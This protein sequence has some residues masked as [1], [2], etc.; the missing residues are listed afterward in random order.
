MKKI[1]K[2]MLT[3]F[4]VAFAFVFAACG[5]NVSRFEG[6]L[7][8]RR[9]NVFVGEI[10]GV[11]VQA[12]TGQREEPFIL[13]GKA[14]GMQ[15]FTLI[16]I[17][18]DEFMGTVE[19]SYRVVIGENEFR[20]E[21]VPHPFGRTYSTNI[22]HLSEVEDMTLYL[23]RGDGEEKQIILKSVLTEDM[24]DYYKALSIAA[25]RLEKQIDNMTQNGVLYAEIFVRLM[26]NPVDNT[27]GFYWYV[28]FL[29]PEGNMYAA[30]IHPVSMEIVAV[31]D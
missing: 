14:T 7:S 24:I 3:T 26:A 4:L 31:R 2:I 18:P 1:K 27:G 17:E 15:D 23:Q 5:I 19:F 20:G 8:E 30:L 16:T 10:D 21:M 13:D 28:A 25:N 12:I 9:I 22:N 6:S 29:T 11:K